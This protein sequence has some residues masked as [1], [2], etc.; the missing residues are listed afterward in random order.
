MT[1]PLRLRALLERSGLTQRALARELGV[2]ERTVR[3]WIAGDSAIPRAAMIA[4]EHVCALAM[5]RRLKSRPTAS[6]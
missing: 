1:D 6:C 5:E 3:R 4:A 2:N